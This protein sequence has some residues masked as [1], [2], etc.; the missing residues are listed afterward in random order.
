M[1]LLP[2]FLVLANALAAGPV[3]AWEYGSTDRGEGQV[4]HH[5]MSLDTSQSA[6][7]IFGCNTFTPG[8]L[9]FQLVTNQPAGPAQI[10]TAEIGI[11]GQALRLEGKTGDVRGMMLL[12][13]GASEAS[14]QAAR[15]VYAASSSIVVTFN[16][17]AYQ[18]AGADFGDG[19][20]AMLDACG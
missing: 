5:A 14:A 3:L 19:F 10:A 15:A 20:G 13:V 12:S 11:E 18:F 2:T 6:N 7:A 9:H 1:R 17:Q 8:A 4:I 16:G